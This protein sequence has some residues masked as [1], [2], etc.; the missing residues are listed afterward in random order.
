MLP[1]GYG[2]SG[3]SKT[4][5]EELKTIFQA[6]EHNELLRPTRLLTG[7][8]DTLFYDCSDNYVGYIPGAEALSAVEKLAS[9]LKHAKPSLIYLLDRTIFSMFLN[10]IVNL[11]FRS[12]HSRHGGRRTYICR[13]GCHSCLQRNV[14]A[15]N[16][17]HPKLV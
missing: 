10:A 3:G 11:F 16:N 13:T 17:Y 1:T 4:T 12:A 9:K 15:G 7:E 8:T 6:M 5:A 2:R 14:A